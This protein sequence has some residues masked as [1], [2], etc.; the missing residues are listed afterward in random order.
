[1]S[2]KDTGAF[3]AS[4]I[5]L[6]LSVTLPLLLCIV[7]NASLKLFCRPLFSCLYG[8]PLGSVVPVPFLLGAQFPVSLDVG[9]GLKPRSDDSSRTATLS[10]LSRG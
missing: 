7:L 2:L 9:A 3:S 8:A 4:P 1:M 10:I 6:A 5:S